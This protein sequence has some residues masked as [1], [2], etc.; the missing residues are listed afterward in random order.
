MATF[1]DNRGRSWGI[2]ISITVLRRVRNEL[3]LNL[4]EIFSGDLLDRLAGDPLLLGELL[5]VLCAEQAERLQVSPEEFGALAGDALA[6]PGG[7]LEALE[8]ALADFFPTPKK[9]ALKLWIQKRNRME[10][11]AIDAATRDLKSDR[12]ENL[13]KKI[14]EE[15]NEEES[16][17]S[18]EPPTSSGPSSASTPDPSPSDD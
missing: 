10:G 11:L 18:S 15:T 7:A 16:E 17:P 12:M 3:D 13:L 14:L 1:K 9:S 6:G 2:E 4:V 5:W 8:V